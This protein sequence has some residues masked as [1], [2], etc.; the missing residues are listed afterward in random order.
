VYVAAYLFFLHHWVSFRWD[1]VVVVVVVVVGRCV[2]SSFRVCCYFRYIASS[3][4]PVVFIRASIRWMD[5]D[6]NAQKNETDDGVLWVNM[7][8]EKEEKKKKPHSKAD[9][10]PK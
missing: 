9:G 8:T 1:V 6:G 3:R 2:D 10:R 7:T 5:E 4:R